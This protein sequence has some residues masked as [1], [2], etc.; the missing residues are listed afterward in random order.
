MTRIA[1][2]IPH[3]T[4]TKDD[5]A[6]GIGGTDARIISTG[7]W[8]A[9]YLQKT[10]QAKAEDLSRVFRVQLGLVTENLH[11]RFHSMLTG[12][13]VLMWDD[14]PTTRAAVLKERD[15]AYATFDRWMGADDIPL[16]MKHTNERS[17]L[18][19][20][21]EYYMGQL[22]WQMYV[23]GTERLRFSII[24]G[25]NEPEWGYV[26]R[27]DEYLKRLLEQVDLFW[28]HVIDKVAPEP[29]S[30]TTAKAKAALAKAAKSIPIN[31]LKPYDMAGNNEWAAA[32]A[33][34]IRD[35][36]AAESL[37]TT[38]PKIRGMIPEDASEVTGGGL[39]FKRDARGAYRV[40]IDDAAA[41]EAR[42]RARIMGPDEQQLPIPAPAFG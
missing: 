14:A 20:R 25:N 16:E 11:A 15:F 13:S 41:E 12:D 9:L 40:T 5:R 28:W 39:L 31:G 23:G 35:K 3:P 6:T 42:L 22:Q 27:D 18:R 24:R 29:D 38:E 30:P 10:G 21:A 1:E 32:A 2:L 17:S 34:F 37:K 7:Q 4:A 36:I 26:A 19:D 8:H 33:D